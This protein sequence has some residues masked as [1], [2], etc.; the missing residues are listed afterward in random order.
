LSAPFDE[1][2]IDILFAALV[3]ARG[4]LLAVSGGPDSMALM[5]LA[6]EWARRHRLP[7]SAATVDHGLR[8]E[9][10]AEAEQVAAWAADLGLG[11]AILTWTGEKPRT[12][13][14]ETARSTRYDLLLRHA[15][16]IGADHLLTAH[17]A[18][19]QAE[20]ILFRLARGS[21]LSGLAGMRPV[22]KLGDMTLLR[23]LLA[24]RKS[25]LVEHCIASGQAF[26]RDP[27]NENPAFARVRWRRIAPLIAQNGLDTETLLRFAKRAARA[28]EALR[29]VTLALCGNLQASRS[30]SRF[31]A[32]FRPCADAPEEILLRLLEIEIRALSPDRPLRLE[33]L[34]TLCGAVGSAL[35][36]GRGLKATLAGTMISLDREGILTIRREP[37]RRRGVEHRN[38]DTE[39]PPENASSQPSNCAAAMQLGD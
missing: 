25:A 12:R 28:D 22:A 3:P 31:T 34:E 33:R 15:R 36:S 6:A 18:D 29:Q 26:L 39:P 2:H 32:D 11:H 27:S 1:V 30:E 16:E 14:Q 5:R 19:D 8:A 24:L 23:P 37:A 38:T 21:G 9:S 17:H 35:R 10:R 7:I 4:A 13:I 20:T